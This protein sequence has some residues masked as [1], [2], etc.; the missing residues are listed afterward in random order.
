MKSSMDTFITFIVVLL[1]IALIILFPFAAIWALNTLFGLSIAYTFWT[2]LAA[3]VL[4]MVFGG[5][6]VS[7]TSKS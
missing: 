7:T 6:R 1:V 5:S 3:V 4:M 2:W